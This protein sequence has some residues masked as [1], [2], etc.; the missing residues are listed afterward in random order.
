MTTWLDEG[1]A[2]AILDYEYH[3]LHPITVSGLVSAVVEI[4]RTQTIGRATIAA[5]GAGANELVAAVADKK[6]YVLS[7]MLIASGTV[8]GVVQS[9]STD[10]T[11][12]LTLDAA[13][14]GFILPAGAASDNYYF[15]C[16][17]NEAL[18]LNLSD[19]VYVGGFVNYLQ[20]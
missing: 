6:I 20:Y 1:R 11:G 14:A 17:T 9:D 10:L 4:N 2:P 7:M 19:A 5:S 13:G 3:L 12:W 16:D 8:M 18:N 15:E